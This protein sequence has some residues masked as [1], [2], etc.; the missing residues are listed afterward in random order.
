MVIQKLFALLV[1]VCL[2]TLGFGSPPAP[3][4]DPDVWPVLYIPL[5]LLVVLFAWRPDRWKLRMA[6]AFACTASLTRG[7]LFAIKFGW[8][9]PI[10]LS[11]LLTIF[12]IEFYFS[13]RVHLPEHYEERGLLDW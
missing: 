7:V 8:S 11:V 12:A 3:Y 10:A 6:T 1:A 2:L 5:A 9:N 13:H 4:L